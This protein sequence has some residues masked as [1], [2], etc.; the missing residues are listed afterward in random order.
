MKHYYRWCIFSVHCLLRS[1]PWTHCPSPTRYALPQPYSICIV[2]ALL[3]MHCPSPTRYALPQPYSIC[4]APALLHMHCPSPTPYALPQPY[5]ICIAPALLD[6]HCPSPTRYALPQPYSI[7]IAPALLD[8]HCPQPYSICI[9]PALLDMHCPSP[10]RYA[11]PQPYSICIAP[12]LLDMHGRKAVPDVNAPL[13]AAAGVLLDVQPVSAGQ[14]RRIPAHALHHHPA[15]GRPAPAHR[16]HLHL[17]PVCATVLFQTDPQTE[18]LTS[19]QDQELR[20][21]VVQT[22]LILV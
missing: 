4:I 9:A 7:C 6:M 17:S 13:C 8:M 1:D 15:A 20:L 10:T 22:R 2:P 5:S 11:L 12:A 21:R 16:Q 19:H 3:H 14:W 18:T